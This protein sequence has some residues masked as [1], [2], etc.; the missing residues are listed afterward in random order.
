MR[1]V[2]VACSSSGNGQDVAA[3]AAEASPNIQYI[4]SAAAGE[5]FPGS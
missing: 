3:I 5:V 1:R 4:F 2:D